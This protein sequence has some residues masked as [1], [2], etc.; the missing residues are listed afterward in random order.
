MELFAATSQMSGP[1][2]LSGVLRCGVP[3]RPA[4]WLR[5]MPALRTDGK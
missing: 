2:D 1:S 5:L 4:S 3:A